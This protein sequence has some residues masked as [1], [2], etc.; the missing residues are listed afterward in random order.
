MGFTV[1]SECSLSRKYLVFDY[2]DLCDSDV[3]IDEKN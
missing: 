1:S 3:L 2:T